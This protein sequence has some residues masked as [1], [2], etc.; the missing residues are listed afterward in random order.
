LDE[1]CIGIGT[2][3][4]VNVFFSCVLLWLNF[5]PWCGFCC[6]QKCFMLS[7]LRV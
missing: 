1:Q 2:V 3:V 6:E 7:F 5:I 4:M